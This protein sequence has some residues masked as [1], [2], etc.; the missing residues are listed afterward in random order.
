MCLRGTRAR[1][2]AVLIAVT[3][4]GCRTERQSQLVVVVQSDMR[5]PEVLD[6]FRVHV[7]G[8]ELE[9]GP[10]FEREFRLGQ[11]GVTLPADF[12]V[13]PRGGD[14]RRRVTVA[15]DALEGD[16]ILFTTRAITTFV[17]HRW[18]R[19]DIFLAANCI[20]EVCEPVE[21]CRLEGCVPPEVDPGD[22]DTFEPG[23]PLGWDAGRRPACEPGAPEPNGCDSGVD[24]AIGPGPDSGVDSGLD[25]GLDSG[26]DAA[27]GP[28]VVRQG[29]DEIFP[30]PVTADESSVDFYDYEPCGGR[31]GF[32]APGLATIFV[33]ED[34]NTGSRS[35]IFTLSAE[36]PGWDVPD[37][38]ARVEVTGLGPGDPVLFSDDTDGFGCTFAGTELV[39]DEEG[40]VVGDF[41]W[42]THSDGG[43]LAL[44]CPATVTFT[45]FDTAGIDELVYV[46]AD[47]QLTGL[48][49]SAPVEI[50][51]R[52]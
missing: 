19:L 8:G 33:Y 21:T 52:E 35:L 45:I 31:T 2:L 36:D 34:S 26:I 43:V 16:R 28:L 15:V 17:A 29:D 25:S 30:E 22:L 12:G 4:T 48:D 47:G 14:V 51:C 1:V 42:S 39:W 41:R 40:R 9:E 5:V 6:G 7:T 37:G 24:S 50:E 13:V 18:L 3:G 44:T 23:E 20:D 27:V 46:Q 32:E 11:G 10:P 49:L 38:A